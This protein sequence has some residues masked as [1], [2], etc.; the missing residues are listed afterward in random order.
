LKVKSEEITHRS[1]PSVIPREGVESVV[2]V[3]VVAQV[4]EA[5]YVIP[6]E[7]VERDQPALELHLVVFYT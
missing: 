5:R 1:S 7:G 3:E 2:K 6:R 4:V